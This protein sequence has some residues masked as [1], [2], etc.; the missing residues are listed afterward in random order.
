MGRQ[1]LDTKGPTVHSS[2]VYEL[3]HSGRQ[4]EEHRV[5]RGHV[6]P[7]VRMLPV[8]QSTEWGKPASSHDRSGPAHR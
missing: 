2:R 8:Q 1:D 5:A 3:P 6:M 4:G 7:H